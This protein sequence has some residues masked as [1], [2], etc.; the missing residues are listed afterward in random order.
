MR[1][2]V[3]LALVAFAGASLAAEGAGATQITGRV[4]DASGRP[5]AG[6][7]VSFSHGSPRHVVTVLTDEAGRYRTPPLDGPSPWSLR[8]RKPLFRDVQREGVMPAAQEQSALDVTLERETD[9]AE[10][11]AQ[12]PANRWFSLVLERIHDE[13]ER[14]E[15]VRQCA[16]CHQ[17]GS[18]YTRL[19]RT[20]E[21][22]QKVLALMARMGGM[23]GPELRAAL[24]SL[25]NE[26]YDPKTAVPALVA[27][28]DEP[29]FVPEPA[30]EARRAVIEE[31]EMG[32]AASMQHDV[33]VHP[34]GS[35]WSVDQLQDRLTRLDP[36]VAGGAREVYE[37]P[38]GD[39]PLG[40]F[41]GGRAVLPPNAN[42]HVGPHSLQMAPD[43]TIWLTLSF[44]NQIAGFDPKTKQW[45]IHPLD[46]GL[47]PHTLR[48][49]SRGRIWFSV[50]VSNHL[51]MLD[52][53]TGEVKTI[54]LPAASWSQELALRALPAFFWLARHVELG[55]LPAGEGMS[56]PVPYGVDV[57]PDGGVWFS[58]LNQHRIGR[59]DPETLEIDMIDTPFTGP[60]RLRFD[61][62]G[63]LWI[64]G[65][66]SDLIARFDPKTRAFESWRLPT[67]PAGSETPYALNVD[68]R[69]DIV[70][71]CG[72]GSDSLLRFDPAT[73]TFLT[74]PL[75]TRVT[76]TR[77]IDFDD[78]GR[79]W[80]SNSNLPTWQ[81]E[82]AYP[83]VIRVDWKPDAASPARAAAQ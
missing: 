69:T 16:Y 12:L 26:T 1:P 53:K 7:M 27:R 8:V 43:G 59:I 63:Q 35:L 54:R 82:G 83:R 42:A 57:A 34:D 48:F 15:L 70:W 60:R 81:V 47:Y 40:G 71:I 73:Q 24:P 38:R 14:E 18:R 52:R 62:K 21:N 55:E 23:I 17:Q 28:L 13:A 80:T 58:Q 11:A 61:S 67:V 50:A 22:W 45:E 33:A 44:G 75:P 76:F 2:H 65:F 30:P 68:R 39:L 49:D 19:P 77:E 10:I 41:T 3:A 78:E 6:T 79:V 66:S 72:T 4:R 37:V 25:F 29:G 5:V 9:P 36:S 46:E 31:W 56:L 20:E 51:G 32:I 74:L 64:P